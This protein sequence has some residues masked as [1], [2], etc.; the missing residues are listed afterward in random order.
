VE[1]SFWENL[2]NKLKR[3]GLVLLLRQPTDC[4]P[5]A[6]SW[7]VHGPRSCPRA[8]P[9]PTQ[10]ARR[11]QRMHRDPQADGWDQRRGTALSAT[12][13][14]DSHT[15]ALQ[16]ERFPWL[17]SRSITRRPPALFLS[18]SFVSFS[19]FFS[20]RTVILYLSWTYLLI[21]YPAYTVPIVYVCC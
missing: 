3:R 1:G 10:T 2:E 9:S 18:F 16:R 11:A 6:S 19:L 14:G 13:V 15:G 21:C 20:L 12:V 8:G 7:R 4:G 5:R 17:R